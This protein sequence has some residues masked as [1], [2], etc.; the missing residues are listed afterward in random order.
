M[1]PTKFLIFSFLLGLSFF[2]N[3]EVHTGNP[4]FSFPLPNLPL[5]NPPF[6]FPIPTMTPLPT[7]KPTHQPLQ[8]DP[9]LHHLRPPR[10]LPD[11]LNRP[12]RALRLNLLYKEALLWLAKD[13]VKALKKILQHKNPNVQLLSLT[14]LETMVKDCGDIVHQLAERNILSQMIKI[15]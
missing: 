4:P 2:D 3:R 8:H 11:L 14:L 15:V 7:P 13:V 9:D 10:S 12:Q 5:P 6:P 1:A